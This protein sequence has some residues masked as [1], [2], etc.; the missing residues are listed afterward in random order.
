MAD[1][2]AAATPEVT[3]ATTEENKSHDVEYADEEAK[4]A[5]SRSFQNHPCHGLT[6]ARLFST[7][8]FTSQR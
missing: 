5:V 2:P 6:A 8:W 4:G 3:A 1:T 7:L